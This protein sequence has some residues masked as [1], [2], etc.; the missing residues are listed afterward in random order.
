MT[1]ATGVKS[2]SHVQ[3]YL[4]W[5]GAGDDSDLQ[6]RTSATASTLA[7][8]GPLSINPFRADM[9]LSL[10]ACAV[11]SAR[12]RDWTPTIVAVLGGRRCAGL[13]AI[14]Q[15]KTPPG[16]VVGG[17]IALCCMQAIHVNND[18]TTWAGCSDEY[19]GH[20]CLVRG[21]DAASLVF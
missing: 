8:A 11:R 12:Q 6:D 2:K 10:W 14:L 21:S 4:F 15:V 18:T 17:A 19:F 5:R 7:A 9:I 13:Y 3:I 16:P 20:A 1:R